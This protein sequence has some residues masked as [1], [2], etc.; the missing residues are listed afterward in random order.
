MASEGTEFR[1]VEEYKA[2]AESSALPL[3]VVLSAELEYSAKWGQPFSERVKGP[4]PIRIEV[5]NT[6]DA[7]LKVR[8]RR[9]A[10]LPVKV[11]GVRVQLDDAYDFRLEP[12]EQC[13]MMVEVRQKP[14]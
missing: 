6:S 9:G 12:F 7:A 14:H 10:V 1:N 3:A 5:A 11:E 13:S 2:Q 4:F 8:M